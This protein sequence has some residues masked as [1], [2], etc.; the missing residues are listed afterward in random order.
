MNEAQ[1]D[2]GRESEILLGQLDRRLAR[3]RLDRDPTQ[4]E[5]AERLTAALRRLVTETLSASAADRAR[6]RAAVHYFALR[7]GERRVARA[8]TED[9]RVV[10]DILR[11]LGRP[12]LMVNLTPEPA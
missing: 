3:L 4:V 12:D 1:G 10:N 7:R 2:F 8:M 11:L 6:V 9:V 5:L